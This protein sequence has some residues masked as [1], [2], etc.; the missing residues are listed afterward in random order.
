M[1]KATGAAGVSV[2]NQTGVKTDF[3][4]YT[5]VPYVSPYRE[6]DISLDPET[7]ANDVDLSLTN[8]TVVPTRGAVVKADFDVRV[9]NR[10]L[11]TLRL[12]G[13]GVVP[14]GA[15]ATQTSSDTDSAS[16][17]G[18]RGEVYLTGLPEKGSLFVQWGA[19]VTE[20]CQVDYQLEHQ[21]EQNV[22]RINALC[23]LNN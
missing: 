6:N 15:I 21:P 7:L 5:L 18:D 23:H 17:V 9:G 16:I 4:G 12:P 19:R 20:Q 14:F 10:V 8:S 3:R 11:M 13:S 22:S 2:N 1:V